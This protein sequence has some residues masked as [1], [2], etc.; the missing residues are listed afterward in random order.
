MEVSGASPGDLLPLWM[1]SSLYCNQT[2]ITHT[3]H[4][5]TPRNFITEQRNELA[6]PGRGEGKGK[7]LEEYMHRG[8]SKEWPLTMVWVQ[9]TE[10]N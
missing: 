10:R 9:G 5:N 2:L 8:T 6:K 1:S 4:K 7:D 3:R